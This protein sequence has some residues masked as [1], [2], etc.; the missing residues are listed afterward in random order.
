MKRRPTRSASPAVVQEARSLTKLVELIKSIS[1]QTNL[2]ALNAAIEAARAGEAGRGFAVVADEVRKLSAQADKAVGQINQGI[3]Q[4]ATSIETQFQD[5][6]SNTNVEGERDALLHFGAQLNILG[7][8]YRQ[9]AAHDAEMLVRMRD[10]SQRLSA[11]FMDALASVQFQD[12]TR[13]QIEQVINALD[14]LDGH[15]ALLADRLDRF[16]DPISSCGRSRRI[17]TT[18]TATM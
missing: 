14:R 7:E 11:M 17:S 16:D 1:G 15:A 10:S 8:T 9:M 4:V 13:Q 12:V 18:S 5:K 2:L 6:L 3:Q